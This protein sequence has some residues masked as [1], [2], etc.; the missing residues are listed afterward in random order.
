MDPNRSGDLGPTMRSSHSGAA[1]ALLLNVVIAVTGCVVVVHLSHRSASDVPKPDLP[2]LSE[3]MLVDE[4]DVPPPAG[5]SWGR[6]V[7]VPRGAPPPVNPPECALFLSQG[8][9]L[10]KGLAMR[11]SQGAAIGVELAI[12]GRRVDLATAREHCASFTLD[13]PG[14]RSR[15]RVEPTCLAGLTDDAISTVMHSE[16]TTASGSVSWDIALAAV[17]HRGILVTAEYTPGPRGGPFDSTLA[18]ALPALLQAQLTRL[19]AA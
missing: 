11:S 3:S 10:Q 18:S 7:A 16:T 19:D 13:T 5:T 1:F 4:S 8:D 9:A 12:G 15:V 17:Y 14:I 2:Y 6:I